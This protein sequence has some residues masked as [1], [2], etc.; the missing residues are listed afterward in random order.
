VR[1]VPS[2]AGGAVLLFICS[3]ICLAGAPPARPA[4]RQVD[5][6][7]GA[8]ANDVELFEPSIREML[9][10]KGLTV[11]TTR[12]TVV[13]A[14]DV[15]AA[16]AP[17]KEA[18]PSLARVLLDFTSP[19]QG[20]LFLIDPRRGRVYVRR[21]AL[22]HGLDAVARAGVRF[23][24]EESI[25]AI[26]EGR[27]IGVS[28]EE[29]QRRVVPAPPV[30]EAPRAPAVAAPAPAPTPSPIRMLL[31]G[32]Y[33]LIAMGRGDYQQAAKVTGGA[34]L[35]SVEIV[36][37]G[38]LAAPISIA[39][40]G[41]RTRLSAGAASVSGAGRLVTFGGL[42]LTAGLGAGL[43]IT[44]VEATVTTQDL[45]PAPAFWAMSP[46]L[47]PFAQLERFVGKVSISVT[48]AADVHPL[49]ERYT[50]R[51]G[52]QARDVFVPA[53]VRPAAALLIGILF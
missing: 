38:R 47:E 11:V 37:S 18:T 43:E 48:L 24:V 7:I 10:P 44:R 50:V 8:T 16:I 40:D 22:P 53:H 25:D 2:I 14:Q 52:D 46:F 15:A 17:P 39:G 5:L 34:R 6:I 32:G 26:L 35:A 1:R 51:T 9:A 45:R 29:F 21:M 33:E 42:S 36:V 30:V 31:A 4:R 27:E 28:R 12:K 3:R 41:V 13:T 20:T 23:V 49:A 19:G